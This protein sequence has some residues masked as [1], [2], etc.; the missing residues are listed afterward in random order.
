M[1]LVKKWIMELESAERARLAGN[2]GRARVCAR[3]AAG[4][5]AQAFLYRNRIPVDSPNLYGALL[6]L[7]QFDHL[8]PDLHAAVENLTM[9][10]G[11][12]FSLPPGMDLVADARYLCEH[13]ERMP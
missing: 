12:D 10:V 1:A 6:T 13:L 9:R 2:E 11:G 3:R 7:S 8:S 5:V 4:M